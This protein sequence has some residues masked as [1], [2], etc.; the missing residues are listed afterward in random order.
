MNIKLIGSACLV[1]FIFYACNDGKPAA[2]K[3]PPPQA[4]QSLTLE[5]RSTVVYT[6]FPATIEGIEIGEEGLSSNSLSQFF[7]ASALF[8]HIVGGLTQPIFQNGLNRQRLE[9]ARAQQQEYLLTFEKTI[10]T[11]GQEV[12]DAL[13]DYQAAI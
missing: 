7:D 10:L 2:N 4:Y 6:D 3:T 13:F 11:A 9:V 1:I 12:S 5:P 8:G